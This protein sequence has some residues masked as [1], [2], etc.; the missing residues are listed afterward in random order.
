MPRLELAAEAA[1]VPPV[2]LRLVPVRLPLPALLLRRQLLL[3][4][5]SS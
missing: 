2:L 4:C 1:V 5:S 3:R